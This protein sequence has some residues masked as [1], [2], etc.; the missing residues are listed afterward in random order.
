MRVRLQVPS[1]GQPSRADLYRA[2]QREE[3]LRS[4]LSRVREAA[5]AWR[6]GLAALLAGLI[7][8]GLVKGRSDVTGLRQSF[9]VTVGVLLLASL[10]I[11]TLGA[12]WLMSAAHGLPVIV[13]RQHADIDDDHAHALRATAQLRRGIWATLGCAAVL[14]TA[15]G[16]TWYGPGE[17]ATTLRVTTPHSGIECG[18]RL[19]LA[20]GQPAILDTGHGL[21]PLG[22][23]DG[24]TV[25]VSSSAC[26]GSP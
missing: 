12:L 10:I 16:V 5:L 19:R 17:P 14:V 8:F 26:P 7:G 1:Q 2:R 15:V 3:L 13:S 9:A 20:E 18:S 6:N 24:V 25:S 4:E 21:L 11:G 23:R 22:L